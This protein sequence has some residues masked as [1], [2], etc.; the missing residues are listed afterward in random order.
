M[1]KLISLVP[2]NSNWLSL[3]TKNTPGMKY[4]SEE[5]MKNRDSTIHCLYIKIPWSVIMKQSNISWFC[6]SHSNDKSKGHIRHWSHKNMLIFHP[7][8]SGGGGGVNSLSA[9]YMHRWTRSVLVQVMACCLFGAKPLPVPMQQTIV[10]FESQYIN[11]HSWKWIWKCH[12]H[13]C[14]HFVAMFFFFTK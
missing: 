12:L 14:S 4:S 10:K 2:L 1:I 3:F 7:N 6:I 11:F 13:N 9:A 5:H 8:R